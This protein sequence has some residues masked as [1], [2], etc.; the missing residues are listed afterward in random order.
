MWPKK[1]LYL[2]MCV[3]FRNVEITAAEVIPFESN[4]T[5]T[6]PFEFG[7]HQVAGVCWLLVHIFIY[8]FYLDTWS[9]PNIKQC[10]VK[11]I[12]PADLV[13][14]MLAKKWSST[15]K[16]LIHEVMQKKKNGNWILGV[17]KEI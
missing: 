1:E 5:I 12:L 4:Q 13:G 7:E 11:K 16:I 2:F 17:Q 3:T 8:L 9:N 6:E 10:K 14:I 15:K